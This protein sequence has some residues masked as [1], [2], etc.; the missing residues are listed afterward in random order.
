MRDHCPN[1]GAPLAADARACP[2]CGSDEE[3]GWSDEAQ[4][5]ALGLPDDSFDYDE[6]ASREFGDKQL[7]PRGLH[8][9]WW[10]VAALL[11]AGLALFWF[12]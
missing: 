2:E 8:W 5:E 6:F 4:N 10:V 9:F 7:V 12:R 11:L 1:C 3:T